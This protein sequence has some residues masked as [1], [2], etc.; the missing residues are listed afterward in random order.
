VRV[1]VFLCCLQSPHRWAIPGYGFWRENFKPA[2]EALGCRVIEPQGLDLAEPLARWWDSEWL[3][4]GRTRLGEALLAQVKAAHRT[5]G[6]DLFFSYFYS[7]HVH[8]GVLEAIRDL[9]IPVV[10]FFCDNLRQFESVQPLAR[11]VTMNWVPEAD[12]LP[13]YRALQAPAI[14]LPMAVHPGSYRPDRGAELPQV[15]FVGHADYLRMQ[16][17][18]AV[19]DSHV[20]LRIYGDG[21]GR[22][23]RPGP[24]SSNVRHAPQLPWWH[25]RRLSAAQHLGRLGNHGVAAEWR[26]FEARRVQRRLAPKFAREAQPAVPHDEF[27]RLTACSAVTLG[28]N[29]CPHPAYSIERPLVYSRLRD[30]EAPAMGAC[31]LTEWC[32]EL[33]QLYDV[34][35]EIETYRD[36]RELVAKADA[37]MNDE[38]RRR[39][40]RSAGREAVHARHT[41]GHRFCILFQSLGIGA[42][43]VRTPSAAP[44]G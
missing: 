19:V 3:E 15:T 9:G 35:R 11:S 42:V 2:L 6:I 22:A 26:Y 28:I 34:G 17:L 41:W 23:E 4:G 16:L 30:I 40:L 8:A 24:E 12:A 29:R 27:V 39:R 44:C 33:E 36:A 5:S 14:H 20:P 18:D 10:N 43:P 38:P 7:A 25:R 21:W 32:A 31:Y 37:L 1:N 13:L